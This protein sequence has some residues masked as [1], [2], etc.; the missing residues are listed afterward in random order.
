MLFYEA[1]R[2]AVELGVPRFECGRRNGDFKRRYGL[3]P[4]PLL[5]YVSPTRRPLG[6]RA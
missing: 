2:F 1:L 3:R 6:V 4:I 5:A